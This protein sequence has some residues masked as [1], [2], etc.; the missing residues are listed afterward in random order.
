MKKWLEEKIL[1]KYWT[2]NCF[3]YSL[4]DG[5]KIKSAQHSIPFDC[6]PDIQKNELDDGTII[7]AEVSGILQTLTD[8]DMISQ[9][10]LTTMVF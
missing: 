8:M 10:L 6:Y 1:I 5:R 3:K 7:P 4:R 2:E 9:F